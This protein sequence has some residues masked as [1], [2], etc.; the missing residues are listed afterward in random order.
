MSLSTS[1]RVP[2]T[3]ANIGPGF[4][5]VGLSLSLYLT[6]TISYPTI[7]PPTYSPPVLIYSGEGANQV[8]LDPYKNLITRVALYVLRCHNITRFPSLLTIHVD[9][10]IPFGRGLGSSG[11]AVIAGVLL[12]NSLGKLDL[13]TERLLD[14]ALMVERH[15]DNV[16][17]ALV[18]GF[19]GSYL[20]ELDEKASEAASVPLS[21]ILPEYPP[22]VGEDWGMNPPIPPFGIGHYV[23]FKWLESIKAL[24]IIPRFELSTAKAREVLP[25]HYTRKDL[26]RVLSSF[27][28]F[29]FFQNNI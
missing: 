2:A 21:E 12:A 18:G 25:T 8:S 28:F 20:R 14:F 11:A 16:T 24:A 29:F 5:V 26:V 17:A 4:D 27:S 1:I 13:P 22:D 19:V 10:Q 3:S 23:R 9:N 7:P 6:L 15:P